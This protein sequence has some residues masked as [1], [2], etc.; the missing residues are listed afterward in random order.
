MST[1]SIALSNAPAGRSEPPASLA[2]AWHTAAVLTLL[3]VLV[4]FSQALRSNGGSSGA[5]RITGYAAA[6]L[7][8]WLI[9]AF[10]C[11]RCPL[12]T[13]TGRLAAGW[14]PVLRDVGIATAFLV[15]AN[16]VLAAFGRLM[17]A[18]P[19]HAVKDLLPRT[20]AETLVFLLLAFTAAFCEEIVYRGYLQTQ[21]AAWTGSWVAATALQGVIFGVTHAWQGSGMVIAISLYGCLFGLL[22][23][24]R[25][26]L[27]PGM[28]AHFLQD[29]IGGVVLSRLLV[30]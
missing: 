23:R 17:H 8:E 3:A 15:S 24:W 7:A 11:F 14:R 27:R 19:N 20:E 30:R 5:G 16:I 10:I 22:A 2:P 9:T 1:L 29:G 13:L 18:A 4:A 25:Q 26:S 28:I 12:Q 21:F 6:M